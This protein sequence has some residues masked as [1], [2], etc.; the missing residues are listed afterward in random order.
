MVI[1]N[2]NISGYNKIEPK[3]RTWYRWINLTKECETCEHR[4]NINTC[5]L[6][7]VT[8]DIFTKGIIKNKCSAKIKIINKKV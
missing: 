7:G 8:R 3:T 4:K 5:T 6:N 2:N 1:I